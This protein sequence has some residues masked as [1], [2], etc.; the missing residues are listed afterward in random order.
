[1]GDVAPPG[2][3]MG[4]A[5]V[6]GEWAAMGLVEPGTAAEA[7]TRAVNK[8]SAENGSDTPDFILGE[9]LAGVLGAFDAATLHRDRWYQS[10]LGPVDRRAEVERR[11]GA[12]VHEHGGTDALL[13]HLANEAEELSRGGLLPL[14]G[15]CRRDRVTAQPEPGGGQPDPVYG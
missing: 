15:V 3:Q 7:F 14:A 9:F 5:M 10:S 6:G 8:V 11:L 13:F 12:V 4:T 2:F 1:M